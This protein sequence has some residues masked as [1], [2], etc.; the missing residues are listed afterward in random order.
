MKISLIFTGLLAAA[1][2]SFPPT[3]LAKAESSPAGVVVNTSASVLRLVPLQPQPLAT[4]FSVTGML[5]TGSGKPIVGASVN[6]LVGGSFVGQAKTDAQG[7]A[8]ITVKTDLSAG[9][10]QLRGIFLGNRA[11]DGSNAST[12]LKILPSTMVVQTVPPMPNIQFQLADQKFATG[13]DGTA[14]V[15]VSRAGDYT[16]QVLPSYTGGGDIQVEFNRWMDDTYVPYHNFRIPQVNPIQVGFQVS[17]KVGQTFVDLQNQPVNVA[18]ITAIKLKSSQGTTLTFTDGTPRWLPA[19]L[20]TRRATGLQVVPIQY[21]VI[22]VIVDG[23]N[24]VSSEQQRFYTHAGDI[25]Q[26]QLLLFS[27][28]ISA[29]DAFFGTP[30]G[31]GILL[32]YPDGTQNNFK[33]GKNNS[34]SI[35]S[36]AR[37]IYHVTV[38]GTS[39]FAPS[40]PV[41]LSQNQVM[42][43]SVLSKLDIFL[44]VSLACFFALGLII[45]GRTQ[46][47]NWRHLRKRVAQARTEQPGWTASVRER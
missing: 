11:Y 14:R 18:R 45:V 5:T 10:Y 26:I 4:Q 20:V 33:F 30:I 37:G 9:D 7:L 24:V 41:A 25:W 36:L 23:S 31:T 22:A 42:S 46:L 17:Y 12:G 39:G 13:A 29:H 15:S 6:F 28:Q 44:G 34:V 2:L 16:L 19:S 38:T 32:E 43:L 35:N 8:S 40:T 47:L 3:H 27:A 1:L 21:G